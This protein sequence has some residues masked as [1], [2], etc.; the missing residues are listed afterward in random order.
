MHKAAAGGHR[1]VVEA[2]FAAGVPVDCGTSNGLDVLLFAA[3]AGQLELLSWR[4]SATAGYCPS[5]YPTR[6][7]L[8]S[9][10]DSRPRHQRDDQPRPRCLHVVSLVPWGI[11]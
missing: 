5:N 11:G 7:S 1:D 2:L 9:L 3:Q 4:V 10:I 8:R 6:P